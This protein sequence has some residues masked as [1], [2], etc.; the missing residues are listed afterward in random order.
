MGLTVV[1][2]DDVPVAV[3]VGNVQLGNMNK[4]VKF[5][6]EVMGFSMLLHF[7][8][9]DISIAVKAGVVRMNKFSGLPFLRARTH[10]FFFVQHATSPS[11]IIT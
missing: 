9:E 5:F 10:G 7:D 1:V 11:C 2:E 4:W 8:D 3:G 6:E